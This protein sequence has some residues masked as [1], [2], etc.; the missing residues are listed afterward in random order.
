MPVSTVPA[1]LG[2]GFLFV[3]TIVTLTAFILAIKYKANG[4]S[5]KLATLIATQTTMTAEF[6]QFMVKVEIHLAEQAILNTMSVKT[7]SSITTKQEDIEKRTN[8]NEAVLMFMKQN[9]DKLLEQSS[10]A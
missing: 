6:R 5:E 8:T 4:D 7:L 9:Y 1:W 2:F 10:N 3:S